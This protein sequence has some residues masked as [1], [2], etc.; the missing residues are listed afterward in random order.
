LKCLYYN[1]EQDYYNYG[2]GYNYGFQSLKSCC[3]PG[4][5]IKDMSCYLTCEA[6]FEY[7]DSYSNTCA[8][9]PYLSASTDSNDIYI[10]NNIYHCDYVQIG[11]SKGGTTTVL[12][13]LVLVFVSCLAFIRD[14]NNK[15]DFKLMAGKISLVFY[16][17]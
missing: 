3:A 2:Y 11:L 12:F 6:P 16:T 1:P 9:F 5:V 10:D 15:F 14:E 13:L 17:T 8:Q 4:T 7:Y